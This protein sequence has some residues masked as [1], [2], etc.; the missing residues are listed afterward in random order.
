MALLLPPNYHRFVMGFTRSLLPLKSVHCKKDLTIFPSPGGM[1]LTKL[2]L[3]GK[4]LKNSRPGRVWSV[5]HRLGTGK[6]TTFFYSVHS[7]K[8]KNHGTLTVQ[9]SHMCQL[10]S[11]LQNLWFAAGSHA[12]MGFTRSLLPLKSVPLT[13][14]KTMVPLQRK[15]LTCA[16]YSL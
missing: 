14:L 1:S 3:A 9:A 5:T 2:S 16:T 8:A 11:S 15:H 12:V 13:R 10:F 6:S 4:N 7:N